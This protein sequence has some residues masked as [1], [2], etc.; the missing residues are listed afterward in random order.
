MREVAAEGRFE[1]I[2]VRGRLLRDREPVARSE[3]GVNC[4]KRDLVMRRV[5][6]DLEGEHER[7]K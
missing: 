1:R 7:E 6:N 5:R 4:A 2:S 3:S